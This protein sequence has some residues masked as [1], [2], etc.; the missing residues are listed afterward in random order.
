[1]YCS[2]CGAENV[3]GAT[4]C[5]GC[6][7]A[8]VF[9]T[10][11]ISGLAIASMVLGLVGC[12]KLGVFGAASIAGLILGVVALSKIN[13]SNGLLEGRGFAIAGV[14]TSAG[15]LILAVAMLLFHALRSLL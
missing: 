1:M 7:G 11:R 14:A 3:E 10:R 2:K 5:A 6:G 12:S 4:V 9:Q 8:F 13:K 15:V